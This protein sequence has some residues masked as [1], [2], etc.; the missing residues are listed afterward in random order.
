MARA[1]GVGPSLSRRRMMEA[2]PA[3]ASHEDTVKKSEAKDQTAA[4][5]EPG[6]VSADG[7]SSSRA[8]H[9]IEPFPEERSIFWTPRRASVRAMISVPYHMVLTQ[10]VLRDIHTHVAAA[11]GTEVGGV[12]AGRLYECPDSV[13]RWVKADEALPAAVPLREDAEIAEL[14]A[15]FR[16]LRERAADEGRELVGWYHSHSLLGVFLS[17]RDAQLHARFFGAPWQC[18]LV[19]VADSDQPNGGLFQ[20]GIRGSLRRS[21]YVP[22]F[23]LLDD[24]S[25]LDDGG[26]LTRVEWPNYKT[27][28]RRVRPLSS[29]GGPAERN[30]GSDAVNEETAAEDDKTPRLPV[31]SQGEPY[32]DLEVPLVLPAVD[33]QWV[34]QRRRQRLRTLLRAGGVAVLGIG[35]W[36]AWGLFGPGGRGASPAVAPA[37]VATT[38]AGRVRPTFEE[39]LSNFHETADRYRE[40]S[41]DHDLGRID[42]AGLAVGYR[43]VDEAFLALSERFL[44]VDATPGRENSYRGAGDAMDEVDRHFDASGCPRPQ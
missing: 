30:D 32:D 16:P 11:S 31:S 23:E 20:Q 10:A 19:L 37:T 43:Q 13:R 3:P 29:E 22:F 40:R 7:G 41:V 9:G 36:F 18:A 8:R 14:E 17:E 15:A 42:C 34:A 2:V 25:I 5:Y 4:P 12:L 28:D 33:A 35:A 1:G 44:K 39:V 27:A 26:R 21:L 6:P 24:A 38:G